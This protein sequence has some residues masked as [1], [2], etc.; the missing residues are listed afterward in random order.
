MKSYKKR[1]PFAIGSPSY[2]LPVEDD[3]LLANVRF[4]KDRV[5]MVQLLYFGKDHLDEVMSPRIISE[6]EKIRK[7]SGLSYTVHLPVD[8]DLLNS[9]RELVQRSVYVIE[10]IVSETER[11]SVDG[12]VLHVDS[13]DGGK[14]GVDLSEDS[15]LLFREAL[16]LINKRLGEHSKG[17]FIENTNYDLLYF[18]DIINDSPFGVCMDVGHLFCQGRGISDYFSAFR[19]RIGQIHIHGVRDGKDHKSLA[20]LDRTIFKNIMQ[21]IMGISVPFIVEVYN[22]DD[23]AS[24]LKVLDEIIG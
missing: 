19:S 5:D 18:K 10:R 12:F 23:L 15:Y 20:A 4:L 9:S 8:L 2:I 1:F 21:S 13:L 22:F 24:S 11:L 14:P 6:L 7:E 17:L 16:T 3:N